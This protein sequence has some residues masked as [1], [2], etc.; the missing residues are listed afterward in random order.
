[1]S[2]LNPA[3]ETPVN[4]LRCDSELT[5][6]KKPAVFSNGV[7]CA[8]CNLVQVVRVEK[9]IEYHVFIEELRRVSYQHVKI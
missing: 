3:G 1:M 6:I 7:K 8:K 4:C 5:R 2:K 9:V